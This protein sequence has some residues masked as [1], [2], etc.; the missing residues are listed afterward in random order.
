[1]PIIDN[2]GE[3]YRGTEFADRLYVLA[4]FA[5]VRGLD[6]DDRITT[7]LSAAE[8]DLATTLYG[9]RG[10]DQINVAMALD[11]SAEQAALTSLLYGGRGDDDIVVTYDVGEHEAN[12]TSIALS[13]T[14]ST[15]TGNDSIEISAEG[16]EIS[17]SD[18]TVNSGAGEDLISVENWEWGYSIEGLSTTTINAGSGA[19]QITSITNSATG[20]VFA[21]LDGG[22]GDDVI[23]STAQAVSDFNKN[24]NNKVWG[25]EGDDQIEVIASSF[26]GEAVNIVHG[27]EGDDRISAGVGEY[28]AGSLRHELYGGEGDDR[29]EVSGGTGNF[30]AGNQGD[31]TLVGSEGADRMIGGRGDDFLRGWGGE[32][33]FEYQSARTGERD[34]VFDFVIGEDTIDVSR[35][36]ANV[37]RGG[38]QA[39][40]FDESGNG[41]TGRLWVEDT[42]YSPDSHGSLIYADTG[43]AILTIALL[44]GRGVDA[45]D[46]SASDFIL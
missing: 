19:D 44:D 15:W 18:T 30:L 40:R 9:G 28:A 27:E 3:L 38:N 16:Y 17:T 7:A 8:G 31:D 46:Y 37:W 32:D 35:I 22:D 2:E 41:G 10:A 23:Y 24:A 1:M 34:R 42:S 45:S 36:D 14:V 6:G 25:G 43:R 4:N 29:L 39:F 26:A 20:D 11:G 21:S 33:T 13:T 12:E 5:T